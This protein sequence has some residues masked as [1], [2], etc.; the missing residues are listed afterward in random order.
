LYVIRKSFPITIIK[1]SYK[2]YYL[3]YQT[4]VFNRA[5]QTFH[6]KVKE[7]CL[8]HFKPTNKDENPY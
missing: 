6:P 1:Y 5:F 3:Y 2:G 8:W 4:Y 7:V